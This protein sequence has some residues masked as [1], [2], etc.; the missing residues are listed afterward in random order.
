MIR[1][2]FAFLALSALAACSA[3]PEEPAIVSHDEVAETMRRLA[4]EGEFFRAGQWES[5]SRI[6]N[7]SNISESEAAEL[8]ARIGAQKFSTCLTQEE[9]TEPDAD[10]FSGAQSDCAYAGFR[11]ADGEIEAS[12]RCVTGDIVQDNE[13]TGTYASDRYDFTLTSKGVGP[14]GATMVMDI[15]ARRVGDCT[16]LG[17]ARPDEPSGENDNETDD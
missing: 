9:V 11:M 1:T 5:T 3:E 8:K 14:E 6:L 2:G 12:M 17:S 4:N 7:I 15:S 16:K 10:F 13:L